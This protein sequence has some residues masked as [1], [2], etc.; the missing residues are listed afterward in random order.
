MISQ[1]A[2]VELLYTVSQQ[3]NSSL[4][5]D[6]V[7]GKVLRFTVEATGATRGSLFLLDE[8]GNVVRRIL[9]RPNLS[10]EISR[11]NVQ[12]VMS[13]G[14]AGWVY[15]QQQAAL[16]TD[17]TRD[18]RW[19][20]LP[21]DEEV[22]GAALVVPLLYQK[23]VNGL[24]SLHHTQVNFFNQSHLSLAT[25]IAGQ[26]AIAVENA[27]LFTQVKNEREALYDLISG[28]PI[29]V[30]VVSGEQIEFRNRAAERSLLVKEM[31][32]PLTAVEGGEELKAVLAELRDKGDNH[33]E[34]NWPDG[35]VFSVS[36]NEVPRHGTV[37]ALDDITY[38]KDL[39]AMKSLFVETVSHDLKNPLSVI[40]GFATLLMHSKSLSEQDRENVVNILRSTGQMQALIENL[41]DLAEI[42]AGLDDQ[43]VSCDMAEITQ[44]VLD[45]FKLKTE[46]KNMTLTA[47]L[48]REPAIVLGNSLRL[49]QVVSN[50]VSNAIKYTPNG[51]RISVNVAQKGTE[52]RLE[53]SDNGTGIAPADQSQLF[54]KFYR[55][56]SSNISEWVEGSGLG[57][58]IVK[59]IVEGYGG[60][61]WVE[62]EVGVG[63]TFGCALPI[64]T[65]KVAA[66][67]TG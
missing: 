35:R 56:P 25:G 24:L 23:R 28:M 16:V 49:S 17:T 62:S 61:V 42:E 31:N 22:M 20:R 33:V 4:D 13:E 47:E 6:E 59:A 27:R 2:S 36:I 14:L 15:R 48:P 44:E 58:S 7:L 66:G 19:V 21:D 30:L 1:S 38:L 40:K 26:A 50:Y 67:Q 8:E 32:I 41:L 57:L 9:A 11:H 54:Q 63:S 10:P 51:G 55:V 52:I 65:E 18:K 37:V 53:V 45:Y 64:A 12:K 43:V 34:L 3:L 60:R 5:L 39:N 46:E 29:P